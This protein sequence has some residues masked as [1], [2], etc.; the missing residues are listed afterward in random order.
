MTLNTE[1]SGCIAPKNC[2]PV[3][4]VHRNIPA[5]GLACAQ[6]YTA[7][8]NMSR[9]LYNLFIDFTELVAKEHAFYN[10]L[11]SKVMFYAKLRNLTM[12]GTCVR[13]FLMCVYKICF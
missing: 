4:S 2:I 11:P 1:Q 8:H 12:C 6:I 7:F 3:S 5:S 13:A 10:K 9:I